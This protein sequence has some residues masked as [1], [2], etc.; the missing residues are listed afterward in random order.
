MFKA[1]QAGQAVFSVKNDQQ[2][3]SP[4]TYQLHI[5]QHLPE[6]Q[7]VVPPARL[8]NAMLAELVET[9]AEK[10]DQSAQVLENFWQKVKAQGTPLIEPIDEKQS[11]VTFLWRGAE[12][13]VR[14]WGGVT[15]DHDFMQRLGGTDIWYRTYTV[16]NDTLVD[17]RLAPDVPALPADPMA[18]RRAILA[19][20]QA[21]PL[22]KSPY[23][24]GVGNDKSNTDKY[25]YSSILKL[26]QAPDQAYLIPDPNVAKG[27]LSELVFESEKLGNKRRLFIYKPAGF[28]P[29]QAYPVLYL[30]DGVDYLHKVPTPTILDNMIAQG[31][32]PPLV[33]VLIENPSQEARRT[34]L[35]A[36][37]AFAEV[38]V[39]ELVPFAEKSANFTAF[40]RIIGGSSFGG[41]AS[42]YTVLNYPQVFNKALILSGSFWWKPKE[43]VSENSHYIAHQFA[44]KPKMPLCFFMSAGFYESGKSNIL[45]TSRHLKDVLL[46][47]GYPVTYQEASTAHGYLAWQGLIS[48]GLK[49]LLGEGICQSRQ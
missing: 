45:E 31:L 22:N 10:P 37:P 13:N 16:P 39:Q 4:E 15:T 44:V 25:N 46:A 3:A 18:Q 14:I 5:D 41:L 6:S 17:Y 36:N 40:E 33:T 35:P 21:D 23:F 43:T 11:R 20:V 19:T 49:A 42:A 47:K 9:L 48:E 12:R 2:T 26:P 27:Q 8:E 7:Q 34:E 28:K 29:E 38:L 32:I 30:F 1:E 24:D